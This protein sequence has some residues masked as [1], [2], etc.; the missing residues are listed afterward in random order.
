V[1][2]AGAALSAQFTPVCVVSPVGA[3]LVQVRQSALNVRVMQ[4]KTPQVPAI[5]SKAG[6]ASTAKYGTGLASHSAKPAWAP[7]PYI[8]PI[9]SKTLISSR[10]VVV[11]VIKIGKGRD[12]CFIVGNVLGF[13]VGERELQPVIVTSACRMLTQGQPAANVKLAGRGQI[14]IFIRDSAQVPVRIALDL[15]LRLVLYVLTMRVKMIRESVCVILTGA[16]HIANSLTS[17]PEP[18]LEN[19]AQDLPKSNACNE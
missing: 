4:S 7:T 15:G 11:D 5:V 12:V 2:T 8:A 19:L 16:A 1:L 18:I 10:I 9:A 6:K 17:A 3:V 13:A 14:A